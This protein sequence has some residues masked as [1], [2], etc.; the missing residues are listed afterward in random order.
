MVTIDSSNLKKPLYD[1][2]ESFNPAW[3]ETRLEDVCDPPLVKEEGLEADFMNEL[4][5]KADTT[6]CQLCVTGRAFNQLF[7]GPIE[8]VSDM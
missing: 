2:S 6:N 7:Q 5:V 8:G 4:T 3:R 1:E